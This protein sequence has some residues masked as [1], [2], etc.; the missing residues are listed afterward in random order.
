MCTTGPDGFGLDAVIAARERTGPQSLCVD[1]VLVWLVGGEVE[2]MIGTTRAGVRR[3]LQTHLSCRD[4]RV[5][6][7]K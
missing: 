7:W 4:P 2:V 6:V 3:S 1:D 5:G